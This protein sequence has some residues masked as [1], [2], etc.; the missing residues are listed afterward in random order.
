MGVMNVG[1]MKRLALVFS[2][3]AALA[4]AADLA[5][6]KTV[7]VMKMFRG[8]DQYLASHLISSHVFE[9]VAD[10]KLADTV[11]T[12]Q[13]GDGF[14][15]KLEELF[16]TPEEE[17]PEPPPKPKVD[18]DAEEANPFLSDTVN[19]LTSPPSSFSVGRSKGTI[20]LVDAKSRQVVWSLYD[21]PKSGGSSDMDRTASNIV[22]RL[23]KDLH[24]KP[25]K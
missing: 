9:I 1:S 18:K 23:Y 14:L 10:P 15:A 6:V 12:D 8:M 7:Y 21:P 2:C 4:S 16:P 19:K 24:P 20:F 11:I 25:K 13:L 22:S 17:K 3:S 5:S